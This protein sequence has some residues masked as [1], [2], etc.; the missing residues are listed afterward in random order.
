M[1]IVSINYPMGLSQTNSEGKPPSNY[2]EEKYMKYSELVGKN[3]F[4]MPCASKARRLVYFVDH[5]ANGKSRASQLFSKHNFWYRDKD[6]N[7]IVFD[8]EYALRGIYIKR[9]DS[10]FQKFEN[11]MEELERT[12]ALFCPKYKE[13]RISILDEIVAFKHSE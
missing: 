11:I 13:H 10:E 4:E 5:K 3:F 9:S 8:K 6:R 12:S 1:D 2:K 7:V